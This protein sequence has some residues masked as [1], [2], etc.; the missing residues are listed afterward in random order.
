MSKHILKFKIIVIVIFDFRNKNIRILRE[1]PVKKRSLTFDIVQTSSTPPTPVSFY[2]G[3]AMVITP[4]IQDLTEKPFLSPAEGRASP[5]AMNGM[6]CKRC[7]VGKIY[8]HYGVGP[9]SVPC[10]PL[11]INSLIFFLRIINNLFN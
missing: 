6:F 1:A 9:G 2:H 11:F 4:P 7:G 10:R 8:K 3:R 5:W